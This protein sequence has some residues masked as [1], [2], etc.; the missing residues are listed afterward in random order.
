MYTPHL[1][2]LCQEHNYDDSDSNGEHA[3]TTPTLKQ[4]DYF[5]NLQT[6][7]GGDVFT[8]GAFVRSKIEQELYSRNLATLE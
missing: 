6:Y 5:L 2:P 7:F 1:V 8:K 4:L 3:G